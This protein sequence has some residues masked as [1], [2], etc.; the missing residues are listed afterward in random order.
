MEKRGWDDDAMEAY[1]SALDMQTSPQQRFD[2]QSQLMRYYARRQNTAAF[3]R[4]A[5]DA[6]V[7]AKELDD[8]ALKA[9]SKDQAAS[10][11]ALLQE[12][13]RLSTSAVDVG[14]DN[15]LFDLWREAIKAD[16]YDFETI[17]Q[18]IRM[19]R[20]INGWAEAF[21]EL[22][23]LYDKENCTHGH[24][25]SDT[26]HCSEL[27]HFLAANTRRLNVREHILLFWYCGISGNADT[28]AKG[29]EAALNF[30]PND[31]NYEAEGIILCCQG[32]HTYL[33]G[34]REEGVTL[35]NRSLAEAETLY[36]YGA[37]NDMVR[38]AQTLVAEYCYVGA[39][40]S[41]RNPD[42]PPMKYALAEL[43]SCVDVSAGLTASSFT[44]PEILLARWYTLE[45]VDD[46]EAKR[47]FWP[48]LS[49]TLDMLDY[50]VTPSDFIQLGR[51][52]FLVG[53]I[54]GGEAAFR[55]AFNIAPETNESEESV[56]TS[57]TDERPATAVSSEAT[58]VQE[59]AE[60]KLTPIKEI[61][62]LFTSSDARK[63][64]ERPSSSRAQHP[65]WA[66]LLAT[67][68]ILSCSVPLLLVV[69]W[70]NWSRSRHSNTRPGDGDTSAEPMRDPGYYNGS[71]EETDETA[72]IDAVVVVPDNTVPYLTDLFRCD[73]CEADLPFNVGFW[74]CID[75][76]INLDYCDVC[77]KLMREDKI[78]LKRCNSRTPFRRLQGHGLPAIPRGKV[79]FGGLDKRY[80]E[81]KD[82][83]QW[84]DEL[85]TRWRFTADVEETGT[86]TA[87][88]EEPAQNE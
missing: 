68:I 27:C 85:R 79:K 71:P 28:L 78:P 65:L 60:S 73:G 75:A 52:L 4:W 20:R 74:H 72:S 39:V 35:I 47:N 48:G 82:L 6:L 22:I 16:P 10:A 43:K 38:R 40:T 15:Q 83:S 58:L 77:Y 51:M 14:M 54:R 36:T 69:C 32:T 21:A 17:I 84:Y 41:Q 62:Q 70:I 67:A 25:S 26:M 46:H 63:V 37:N 23:S 24:D 80:D 44:W 50:W 56:Q 19:D 11:A 33:R 2:A 31:Y 7:T 61:A 81:D 59:A 45:A 3:I 8:V 76:Y 53:D 49:T 87:P 5:E 88:D 18:L 57:D 86:V 64:E 30:F 42:F 13:T 55:L 12:F 29:Y 9:V 34:Q 1:T 66:R